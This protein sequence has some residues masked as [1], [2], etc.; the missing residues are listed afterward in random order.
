M[1]RRIM[2]VVA[3]VAVMLGADVGPRWIRDVPF[4]ANK[5]QVRFND[6][7]LAQSH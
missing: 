2:V 4:R 7:A 1:G 3:V 6:P 5:R